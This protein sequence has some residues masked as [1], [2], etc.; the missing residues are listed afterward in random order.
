MSNPSANVKSK[1]FGRIIKPQKNYAV[2]ADDP[3]LSKQWTEQVFGSSDIIV[4]LQ[5]FN[6]Y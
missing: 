1:S 5:Y 6:N 3:L 2:C 4:A